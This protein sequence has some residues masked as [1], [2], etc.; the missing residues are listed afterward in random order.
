[1]LMINSFSSW[2]KRYLDRFTGMRTKYLQD[3]LN[4][5]AYVF[6]VKEQDENGRKRRDC[7]GICSSAPKIASVHGDFLATLSCAARKNK[8]NVTHSRFWP[9]LNLKVP[10]LALKLAKI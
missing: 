7:S 10:F 2:A 5:F 6:R 8:E 4:W 1:M 3:Y 9:F